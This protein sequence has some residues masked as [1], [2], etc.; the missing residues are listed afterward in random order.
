[1]TPIGPD[2]P[3]PDGP[4]PDGPGPGIGVINIGP[5]GGG[6]GVTPRVGDPPSPGIIGVIHFMPQLDPRFS[7]Q[8]AVSREL[9]GNKAVVAAVRDIRQARSS[10]Q[11]LSAVQ[12]LMEEIG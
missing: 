8:T 9:L 2:S 1:V 4:G 12:R 10:A 6:V 5:G 3:G 7:S 11:R